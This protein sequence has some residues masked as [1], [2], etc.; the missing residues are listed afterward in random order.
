MAKDKKIQKKTKELVEA[1]EPEVYMEE[2]ETKSTNKPK[3]KA[4]KK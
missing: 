3:E 1:V 2:E 4:T